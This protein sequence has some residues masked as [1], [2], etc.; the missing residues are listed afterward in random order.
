MQWGAQKGVSVGSRKSVAT[1]DCYCSSVTLVKKL[2]LQENEGE[3][4][5]KSKV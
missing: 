1:V 5:E 3:K 4:E 2:V